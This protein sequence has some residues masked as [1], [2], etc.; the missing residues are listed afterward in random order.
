MDPK[1]IDPSSAFSH[2]TMDPKKIDPTSDF[3]SGFSSPYQK[4]LDPPLHIIIVR[5]LQLQVPIRPIA[6]RLGS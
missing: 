5:E 4:G 2:K 3:F 6:A 1:K